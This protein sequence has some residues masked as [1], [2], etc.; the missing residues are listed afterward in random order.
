LTDWPP[1]GQE[2][3]HDVFTLSGRS[4]ARRSTVH[5]AGIVFAE[6]LAVPSRDRAT[7]GEDGGREIEH[8]D[9]RPG[10]SV[11]RDLADPLS[12]QRVVLDEAKDRCLIGQRVAHVGSNHQWPTLQA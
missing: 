5:F 1:S 3:T 12:I 2:R 11:E 9:E 4:I 10:D 8:V 7:L 6:N